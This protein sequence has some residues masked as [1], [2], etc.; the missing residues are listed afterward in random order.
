MRPL[1]DRLAGAISVARW[2]RL[3]PSMHSV[4]DG[5]AQMQSTWAAKIVG[6]REDPRR[7]LQVLFGGAV[8][9]SGQPPTPAL[10]WARGILPL[11]DEPALDMVA[12]IKYLRDAEPRLTLR[13]A[14]FLASHAM[15]A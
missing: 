6:D 4:V 9:I 3:A 14:T 15:A 13:A 8:P 1:T 7:R 2:R 11:Q 12:A 5:G 10:I